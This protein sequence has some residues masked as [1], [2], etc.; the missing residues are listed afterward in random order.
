LPA[1]IFFLGAIILTCQKPPLTSLEN[2]KKAIREAADAGALRYAENN[3]RM[4][5][6]SM[7]EGWMEMA[8]Q[9]ARLAPFRDYH[10]ADSFLTLATRSAAEA[11]QIARELIRSLDSIA[12]SERNSLQDELENWR[13][14][15]DGSLDNFQAERY[16][17]AADLAVKISDGLIRNRE[18]EEAIETV[19]KGRGSLRQLEDAVAEY[20]NDEARKIVTWRK[21]VWETVAVSRAQGSIAVII[22]K[23]DHKTYLVKKGQLVRTYNCELGYNSAHQKL[24]SGDGATPEGLYQITKVKKNSKYYRALLLNYPNQMDLNRFRSNKSRGIISRHARIGALIEI[25][26][27][28]GKKRDWTDGCIALI[29]Q[30]MDHLLQHIEVGTPVTIV[31]KS[32]RWP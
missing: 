18:Y 23:S 4:A 17:S 7:S 26:G 13:E 27:D 9:N 22:D 31:R 10:K 28:G 5:E 29:N 16:W 14:A 21:W 25:H 1:A 32:D 20:I 24:F 30:D 19:K 15:L 8:R 11:S 3:Y 6:K 12:R 2:A